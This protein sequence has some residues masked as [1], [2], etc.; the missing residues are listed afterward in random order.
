MSSNESSGAPAEGTA[1]TPAPA[2]PAAPASFGSTR[3]SGLARGKRPSNSPAATKSAPPSDYKPTAIEIVSSPREYQNPFAPAA[4]PQSANEPAPAPAARPE[5]VERARPEPVVTVNPA[6]VAS[7]RP[8]PAQTRELFPLDEKPGREVMPA[9]D[10]AAPEADSVAKAELNILPPER[11]KAV[12]AQT[13]ESAGFDAPRP[14]RSEFRS[15]FREARPERPR[16][17]ERAEPSEPLDPSSI[18]EKFLYVRPGVNFA[19]TDPNKWGPGRRD[20][21]PER[22]AGHAPRDSAA[23]PVSGAATAPKSGGFFGWIKSL[24]GGSSAEPASAV[25]SNGDHRGQRRPRG[26]PGGESRGEFRGEGSSRSGGPGGGRRR[27][28]GRGRSADRG[29]YRG[30]DSGGPAAT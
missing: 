18:P 27:R 3:G 22:P 30:G 26:G 21:A 28:G 10:I 12:E 25:P 1:T 17:E 13:W 24:F 16:R 14:P 8:A 5:P 29:G 15:E 9:E 6:P 23:A 2:S 19:P 7:A 11:P 20:R 4:A